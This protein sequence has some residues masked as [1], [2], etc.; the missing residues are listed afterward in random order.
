MRGPG[1]LLMGQREPEE[2]SKSRKSA[3]AAQM[4]VRVF[5]GWAPPFTPG[6][7]PPPP[8]LLHRLHAELE[9]TPQRLV[10]KRHS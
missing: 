1:E 2:G 8:L 9:R 6:M 7:Q 3:Q 5:G 10:P 4:D